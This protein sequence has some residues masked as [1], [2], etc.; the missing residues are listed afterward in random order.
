[1]ARVRIA[2]TGGSGFIGTNLIET[3]LSA[4]HEVWS[5]DIR[6]PVFAA[7]R[8]RFERIDIFDGAAVS[9]WLVRHEPDAVVHLAARTD[10][11]S[12][13]VDDYEVNYEGTRVVACAAAGTPSVRRFIHT[14]TQFVYT[15]GRAP[16]HD[17]DFEPF[18]AYGESKVRSEVLM[19]E[20]SWPFT[21]SIV[22]PTN[23]WGPWH[24]RYRREFWRAVDRGFYLHPGKSRVKRAYGYVETVCCQVLCILNAPEARVAARVFYV[25]DEAIFLD[26]WVDGFH[27]A[28]KGRPARRVPLGLLKAVAR[29]GDAVGHFGIKAPLTTSRLRNMTEEHAAPMQATLDL[30]GPPEITLDEGIKRTVEWLRSTES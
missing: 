2:V 14:S 20:Q 11:D 3:A 29:A 26:D 19:R 13:N 9:D 15:L 23:V 10:V 18:T 27:M 16:S 8:E 24:E 21:W 12:D 5:I 1:M 7:H 4:G 6:D 30:C 25:G 17:Q 28:L 22:R